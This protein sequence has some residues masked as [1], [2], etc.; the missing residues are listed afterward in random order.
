MGGGVNWIDQIHVGDCRELMRRMIADG[1][2]VQCIVTSPPYWALRNYGVDRQI[3]LETSI[4][5]WANEL[6]A[7]LRGISRVLKPTG[8]LWLN[9]GDTYSHHPRDGAPPKGLLLGPER[10]ALAMIEDG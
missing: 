6:R 1:V 3:G 4:D 5:G 2:R 10:V 8:S 9:L 7:V